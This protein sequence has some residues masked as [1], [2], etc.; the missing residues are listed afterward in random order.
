MAFELTTQESVA[1]GLRRCS[2][3]QLDRA[4]RSL[5]KG[6]QDDPVE[7]IHEARKAI[8]KQRALLRLAR[9]VMPGGQRRAA[10]LALRD[11]ARG[12]SGRRDADVLLAT[13]RRFEEQ[14]PKAALARIRARLGAAGGPPEAEIAQAAIRELRAV[15]R[16]VGGWELAGDGWP[17]LEPGLTRTYREGREALRVTLRQPSLEHLHDWRKRVKDLWYDLRLLGAVCGPV[18]GGQAQEADRLGELL[19]EDHD[20]G[21]LHQT[22]L[23]WGPDPDAGLARLIGLVNEERGQLQAE[24]GLRGRRLYA[25]KP[26]AFTGRLRRYWKAGRTASPAPGAERP[27]ARAR[28]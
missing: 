1:D 16:S 12:L 25:E 21:L 26:A 13:L 17:A 7:A 5:S 10:N 28:A 3:E 24:A 15:R 14:L 20:L 4:I 23:A 19:G 27:P 9:G 18:V 2:R 8:K 22:V 11:T 6:L